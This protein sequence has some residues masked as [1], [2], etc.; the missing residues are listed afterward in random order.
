MAKILI[1][2]DDSKLLRMLERTLR[3]EGFQVFSAISAAAAMPILVDNQPD[4][5]ILDWSMPEMDGITLLRQIREDKNTLPVLMLTAR[6]AI[7]SRVEGLFAGADDYLIKPFAPEEL[8]ARIQA[9]LRRT[10]AD[11]TLTFFKFSDISLDLKTHEAKRAD[12]NLMLT[13][14]EFN[15]LTVFMRHPGKVLERPALLGQVWGYANQ[16]EDNVLELYVGYLRRKL[17]QFGGSRVIQT[18]RGMGYILKEE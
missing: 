1:V 9:L 16:G 13:L 7:E 17:E 2:D 6:D 3:L 11:P 8:T 10:A 18:V 15:L 14:T 5:L 4:L 12:R